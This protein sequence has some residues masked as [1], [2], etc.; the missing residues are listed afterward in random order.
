MESKKC[1]CCKKE[2]ALSE[3]QIKYKD[4]N[5]YQSWCKECLNNQKKKHYKKNKEK[6]LLRNDIR[7]KELRNFVNDYK[8]NK[9]CEIC[10]YNKSTIALDFHH[11]NPLIKELEISKAIQRGWGIPRLKKEIEKCKVVCK[12]CHAEI[13][14]FVV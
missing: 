5:I 14:T 4:K 9:S 3:F 7:E 2:K 6:Y 1:G 11:N 10:G 12:N 13:H 8:K